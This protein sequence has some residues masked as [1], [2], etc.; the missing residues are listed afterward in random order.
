M[1][2]YLDLKTQYRGIKDEIDAAVLRVLDSTRDQ[3]VIANLGRIVPSRCIVFAC[4]HRVS[5]RLP[6]TQNATHL[7]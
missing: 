4:P 5:S 1:I 2:P 3:R 7:H 6:K